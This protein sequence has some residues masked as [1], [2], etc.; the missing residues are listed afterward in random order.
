MPAKGNVLLIEGEDFLSD[1]IA[2]ALEDY[3]HVHIAT[4]YSEAMKILRRGGIQL[5]LLDCNVPDELTVPL[6]PEADRL[7]TLVMLM[8]H[9][10]DRM[11]ASA[12]RPRPFLAKPYSL[13]RLPDLIGRALAGAK[14][15]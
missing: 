5:M 1:F 15:E 4:S 12:N 3:Y 6:V 7:G 13:Q 11:S 9:N 10:S 14:S 2:T 8:S